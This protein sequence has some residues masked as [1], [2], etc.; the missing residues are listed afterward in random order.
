M[1]AEMAAIH[2]TPSSRGSRR[3]T[4]LCWYASVL[5]SSPPVASLA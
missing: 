3:A 1:L 2:G 4:T 5:D